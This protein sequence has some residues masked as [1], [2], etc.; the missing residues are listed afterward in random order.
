MI[1]ALTLSLTLSISLGSSLPPSTSTSNDPYWVDYSTKCTLSSCDSVP[2]LDPA[3]FP[4][5][6]SAVL[7]QTSQN[8]D[9]LSKYPLSFSP[10]DSGRA[11]KHIVLDPLQTY[12]EITGFGGALTDSAALTIAQLKDPKLQDL[13]LSSYYSTSGIEY[14]LAR[15]PMASCDF[16]LGVYSYDDVEN[17]YNLENFS[18]DVD[19]TDYTGQKLS[20][21]QRVLDMSQRA[22]EDPLASH[23]TPL[24]LF[25]SP[26][27][28]PAW[29]TQTNSTVKNPSLR[30]E[31]Q[32][33]QAWALYFS[34]FFS[35]YHDEG[36]DF[37]GVTTQNEP[38]G[39]TGAWQDL[40]FSATQML[41]FVKGYLGP[42]LRKTHPDI[43]IMV[44][45][46]QRTHLPEW[47]D[48][49]F[50]DEEASKYIDGMCG[51]RFV[52]LKFNLA[53]LF[54]LCS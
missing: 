53:N 38:N 45:D 46:D 10:H 8:G 15:V 1:T 16:S 47:T 48:T 42:Q 51:L 37:W 3:D 9:R 52:M 44:L 7:Y 25:A 31:P 49:I 27:A 23:A 39:N 22:S 40:K 14:S 2:P 35:A 28:P 21:I 24:K 4:S 43:K 32:V 33:Y 11:A 12:Q 5:H 36:I 18:I 34:K 13:L 19:R 41:D 17:D 26:W 30:D 20:F 50:A 6:D 54:M 29:M